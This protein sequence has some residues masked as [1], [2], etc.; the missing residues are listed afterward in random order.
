MCD[1]EPSEPLHRGQISLHVR[2]WAGVDDNVIMDGVSREERAART[3]AER[4]ASREWPCRWS[5][6]NPRSPVS[7]ISPSDTGR[8]GITGARHEH[9]SRPRGQVI[10][11]RP[12]RRNTHPRCLSIIRAAHPGSGNGSPGPSCG[13]GAP[14]FGSG[15]ARVASPRTAGPESAGSH[16]PVRL[17]L[18]AKPGNRAVTA[19]GRGI[20]ARSIKD[21]TLSPL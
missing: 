16:F 12:Q 8:V 4:H 10:E 7:T 20:G 3:L 6:W 19:H 1:R 9:E 14:W 2:A 21:A 18:Y 11:D 13:S 5:T 15:L 17:Y